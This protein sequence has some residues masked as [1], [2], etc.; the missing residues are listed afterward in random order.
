MR[1]RV[2]RISR[3]ERPDGSEY[4]IV[5][6]D[7]RRYCTWD[8]SHVEGI[9][10]G[11]A[12]EFAFTRSDRSCN[13]TAMRPL[14]LPGF[15]RADRL[16]S[17]SASPR[18]V[19][20]NCLRTAAE[21]I[22]GLNALPDRK[23]AVAVETARTFEAYVMGQATAPDAAAKD[24]QLTAYAL[25]YRTLHGR[26]EKGVRLDVMVRTKEP[27][28]QQI[29]ATRSQAD[30]DRFLRLAEQIERGIRGEVYFPNE[31]GLCGACGYREMCEEW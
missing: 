7:G 19:R 18:F 8:R 24:V 20:M 15:V 23:A 21:L 13:L 1:G 26:P 9:R 25:A 5:T 16:L 22:Q 2:E 29:E 3:S 28:V 11:D 17:R 30:V 14:G 10:E 12:V 27:K 31:T 6:I 4:W